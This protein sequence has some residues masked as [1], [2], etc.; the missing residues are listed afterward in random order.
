MTTTARTYY[1]EVCQRSFPV[2]EIAG[3][4]GWATFQRILDI[5]RA[6]SNGCNGGRYEIR[7]TGPAEKGWV[8]I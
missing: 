7:V 2:A 8:R 3:E 6:V 5:H 1:C 4:G